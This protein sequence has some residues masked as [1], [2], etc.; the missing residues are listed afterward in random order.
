MPIEK[1][2]APAAVAELPTPVPSRS[3]R[4]N[5]A[6]RGDLL[7][8]AL[9]A[10]VTGINAVRA[11]L[12][13]AVQ[14]VEQES[15]AAAAAAEGLEGAAATAVTA[16]ND[17]VAARIAAE[18]AAA[19]AA[20]F[21]PAAYVPKAGAT[22]TGHLAVPA[23]ATGSQVPRASETV[24]QSQLQSSA[25]DATAGRVIKVGGFGIGGA[26]ST[27]TDANA[28]PSGSICQI[29]VNNK[30]GAVSANLPALENDALGVFS[31]L[32][33]GAGSSKVQIAAQSLSANRKNVWVRSLH[34]PNWSPW[35]L[36][37]GQTEGAIT[38]AAGV[39]DC[40]LGNAFSLAVAGN[41]T[42]S[43]VNIPA[44]VYEC[45]LEINHTSGTITM[46]SGTVWVGTAPTLTTN[47]R[48]L[49]FFRRV[50]LGTAGWYASALAGYSQ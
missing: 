36:L 29:I 24:L 18:L 49:I 30:A 45:V 50:S 19:A 38:A 28:A 47:K 7:L 37:S 22:M 39:M 14:Y 21:D 17:A 20:T 2:T 15:T 11:Y 8:G 46:P 23:G 32:T 1:P 12:N 16:R 48:H 40:A 3:D 5:F 4:V 27:V 9:P 42:L 34:D 25:T 13:D 6:V 35:R 41:V 26:I 43:F 33:M 44:D 10:T 31:L